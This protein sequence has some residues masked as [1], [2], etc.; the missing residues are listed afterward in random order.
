[1]LE[2]LQ[3]NGMS[4][5]KLSEEIGLCHATLYQAKGKGVIFGDVLN[6]A[7][8]VR[9]SAKLLKSYRPDKYAIDYL[10][11]ESFLKQ[12]FIARKM[13]ISRQALAQAPTVPEY[14]KDKLTKEIH[15]IGDKLDLLGSRLEKIKE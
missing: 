2:E 1:V 11:R 6:L 13:G 15:S 8:R 5:G 7:R 10:C 4:L 14:R 9:A 3:K 12:T